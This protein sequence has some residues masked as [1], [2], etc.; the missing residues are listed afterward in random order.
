MPTA[1]VTGAQGGIGAA[2]CQSLRKRKY[3]VIG[4]DLKKGNNAAQTDHVFDLADLARA[5][6]RVENVLR[7]I[8]ASLSDGLALLVNNAAVQVVK[9]I[10]EITAEDW[11]LTF[12]VNLKAPFLLVQRFL[13]LLEQAKGAVV[14]IASI[15]ANLTKPGF[16]AYAASKGA[17]VT[18]TRSMAVELGPRG[19]RANAVLPA[20]TDTPMLRAGFAGDVDALDRLGPIHPLGRIARPEEVAEVVAFLAS[21]EA[22][23]VTGAAIEVNGGIGVRIHDPV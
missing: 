6:A 5:P 3:D 16:A 13:P 1:L 22:S 11:D 14:N 18:L 15:H 10:G 4:V 19:I 7:D 21:P 8:E 20:A 9:P 2:I 23:F 12:D 17:L